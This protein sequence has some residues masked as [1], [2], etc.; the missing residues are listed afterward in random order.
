MVDENGKENPQND[1]PDG[2]DNPETDKG[3]QEPD[4]AALGGKVKDLEEKNKQLFVRAKQ[5]EGFTFNEDNK[6]WEKKEAPKPKEKVEVAP[7][8]NTGELSETQLDYLDLKGITSDDEID[9]IRKVMQRTGQTVRQALNDDY[10]QSKLQAIKEKNVAEAAT[11]SSKRGQQG[12]GDRTDYYVAEYERTRKLPD[13]FDA[14]VKVM[15]VLAAK[16]SHST[17]PWRK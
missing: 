9:V 11:P 1:Q 14:R 12:S 7:E 8:A 3:T 13:D 4:A 5:A 2:Q 15:D 16:H 6:R 10:V 17:P